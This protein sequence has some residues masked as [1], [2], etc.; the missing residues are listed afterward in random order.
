MVKTGTLNNLS[1]NDIKPRLD[2][3]KSA[4]IDLLI[5]QA[6]D[7]EE[8][9]GNAICYAIQ[10]IIEKVLKSVKP[11]IVIFDYNSARSFY[12]IFLQGYEEF[13]ELLVD[14]TTEAQAYVNH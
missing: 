9:V 4:I 10:N 3:Y 2:K 12:Y 7:E 13:A 5:F 1:L 6:S 14:I 8:V 11:Q